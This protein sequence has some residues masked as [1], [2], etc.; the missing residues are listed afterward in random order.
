M[1]DAVLDSDALIE[2]YDIGI[3]KFVGLHTTH[4]SLYEFLRGLAYLGKKVDEYKA[5]IE[6][7]VELL[8]L[9]DRAV[10]TASEVYAKLRKAGSLVEDPDL[11]IASICIANGVP[12]VTGNVEH[13][14]RFREH[15]LS[16]R[17]MDD[18]LAPVRGS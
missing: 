14:E 1:E 9:D 10:A 6:A 5:H 18:Y 7:N 2:A 3:E 15:G 17:R 4:I 13:F 8:P 12:I 16:V 11:L